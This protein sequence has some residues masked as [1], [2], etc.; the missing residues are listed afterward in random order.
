MEGLLMIA[1]TPKQ[2]GAAIRRQRRKLAL[3][4][5]DLGEQTKLRQATV[6]AVEAGEPGTQIRTL[7]DILAALDLE[8]VIQPRTKASVD[9]IGDIF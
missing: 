1:R 7:C 9:E 5:A 6:S 2:I 4:Q 3:T 8:F